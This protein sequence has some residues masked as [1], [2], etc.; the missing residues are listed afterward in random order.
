MCLPN[1]QENDDD[2]GNGKKLTGLS[3]QLQFARR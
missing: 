2:N 1:V 3:F